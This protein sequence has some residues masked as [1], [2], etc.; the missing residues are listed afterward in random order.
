MMK[1]MDLKKGDVI[2]CSN[3]DELSKIL[4]QMAVERYDAT[5]DEES[6]IITIRGKFGKDG[7]RTR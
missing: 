2:K 7:A 4:N 6:L 1:K 5:V 3:M